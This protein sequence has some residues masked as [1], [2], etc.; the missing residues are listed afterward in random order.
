MF[1]VQL[2]DKDS[3][4]LAGVKWSRNEKSKREVC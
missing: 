3:G 1:L 2:K 4:S